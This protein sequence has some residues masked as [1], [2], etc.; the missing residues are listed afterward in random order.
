MSDLPSAQGS[1]RERPPGA[2]TVLSESKV[3]KAESERIAAKEAK[4]AD[5]DAQEV[6]LREDRERLRS[7][8]QDRREREKYATRLFLLAAVWLVSILMIVAT[9]GAEWGS[10]EEARRFIGLRLRLGAE[11]RLL[12]LACMSALFVLGDWAVRQFGEQDSA[13][14]PDDP[15]YRGFGPAGRRWART[16]FVCSGVGWLVISLL[17]PPIGVELTGFQLEGGVL[18]ALIT[19]T[20]INVIGLFYIVSRYLFPSD[21]GTRTDEADGPSRSTTS[22]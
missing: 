4:S 19:T 16:T 3:S 15:D 21:V 1:G 9:S 2:A 11:N 10:G 14:D 17:Q 12:G 13:R 8:Q 18:I 22:A 20:T 6:R 7:R 5:L